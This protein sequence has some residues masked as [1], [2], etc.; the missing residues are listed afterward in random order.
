MGLSSR[1]YISAECCHVHRFS[2]TLP[3]IAALYIF[4]QIKDMCSVNSTCRCFIFASGAWS[5]SYPWIS[6]PYPLSENTLLS[7]VA[8]QK[9]PFFKKIIWIFVGYYWS[10]RFAIGPCHWPSPNIGSEFITKQMEKNWSNILSFFFLT[11][12]CQM[13]AY[14]K[15]FLTYYFNGQ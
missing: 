4:A 2:I 3:A 10:S 8:V 13:C 14:R 1:K 6:Y 11:K 7:S 9:S 15:N 5:S 12:N